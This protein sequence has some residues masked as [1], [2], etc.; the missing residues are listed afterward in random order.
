M[1][2]TG[3]K[4]Y[5]LPLFLLSIQCSGIYSW[6][7]VTKFKWNLFMTTKY[8]T[9]FLLM[10]WNMNIEWKS[11]HCHYCLYSE[12]IYSWLSNSYQ[13]KLSLSTSWK[14]LRALM[15]SILVFPAL[16]LMR[17]IFIASSLRIKGFFSGGFI[18]H[19]TIVCEQKR[20]L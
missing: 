18:F 9:V 19:A 16:L 7:S 3:L 20:S 1:D 13:Q 10:S 12:E 2:E 15:G 14:S 8:V 17:L 5:S 4:R 11:I 6:L